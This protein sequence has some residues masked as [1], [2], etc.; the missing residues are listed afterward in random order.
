[1]L[2]PGTS[3]SFYRNEETE[4][5]KCSKS[6]A[7]LVFCGDVES[8]LLAM[9]LPAFNISEWILLLTVLKRA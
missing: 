5:Q 4:L 1:M 8:F 6:D 7:Q 2:E 9:G 3:V